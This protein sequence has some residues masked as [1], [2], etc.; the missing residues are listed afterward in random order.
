MLNSPDILAKVDTG[1]IDCGL[2]FLLEGQ[3]DDGTFQDFNLPVGPAEAWVTA[4]IARLMLVTQRTTTRSAARKAA[5]SLQS[6]SRVGRWSYSQTVEPDCDSTS[7]VKLLFDQF[8][9]DVYHADLQFI[10]SHQKDKGGFATYL[11]DDAWGDA[12]SCVTP[13]AMLAL[14]CENSRDTTAYNW[15]HQQCNEAGVFRG[16][17]WVSAYYPTLM[18]YTLL[19]RAP[20]PLQVDSVALLQTPELLQIRSALDLSCALLLT[21]LDGTRPDLQRMAVGRCRDAYAWSHIG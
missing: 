2:D 3:G 12:H 13:V 5:D 9:P 10:R 15:L 6:M 7:W 17:W 14:E 21:C 16:Y 18:A 20:Q 11:A 8:K 1:A 4:M 19:R